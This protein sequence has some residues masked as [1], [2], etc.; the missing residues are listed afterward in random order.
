MLTVK[1]K[2]RTGLEKPGSEE[3][4][5]KSSPR[6]FFPNEHKERTFFTLGN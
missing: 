3:R 4:S 2:M 5:R 1:D 6:N